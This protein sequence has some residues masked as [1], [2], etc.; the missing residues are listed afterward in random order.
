MKNTLALLA[1]G[2]LISASVLAATT[3]PVSGTVV[4]QPIVLDYAA[5]ADDG[6]EDL[7][8]PQDFGGLKARRTYEPRRTRTPEPYQTPQVTRTPQ[9]TE[10]PEATHTPG[11]TRTPEPTQTPEGTRTPCATRTPEGTRTP[12]AT[13]TPN[14]T[15]TP[16]PTSTPSTPLPPS[17]TAGRLLAS[18]C[19]QCHGTDGHSVSSI[20]SIAGESASEIINEMLEM[21]AKPIG[22]DIMKAHAH[23]YTLDEIRLIA[24]YLSTR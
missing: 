16:Q 15:G 2:A 24:E 7:S 20:D 5:K 12:Q 13:S 23:A 8:A 9:P 22:N 21:S 17:S 19:F 6:C 3:L 18:N 11:M 14:G 10:T 4:A 1:A